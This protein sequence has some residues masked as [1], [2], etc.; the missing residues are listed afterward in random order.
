MSISYGTRSILL[1]HVATTTS[2]CYYHYDHQQ[3]QSQQHNPSSWSTALFNSVTSWPRRGLSPT[4]LKTYES[5]WITHV[6]Y[7]YN[8]DNILSPKN[9]QFRTFLVGRFTASSNGI[10]AIF[11]LALL[12]LSDKISW[13]PHGNHP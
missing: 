8:I 9:L 6:R 3:L 4:S 2:Y 10:M 5:S 12:V 7:I 13:V 11:T 1:L